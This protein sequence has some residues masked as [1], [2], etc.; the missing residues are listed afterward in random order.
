VPVARRGRQWR[1][2][3]MR[4][5]TG[6]DKWGVGGRSRSRKLAAF[7][8]RNGPPDHFVRKRTA[9]HSRPRRSRK[10]WLLPFRTVAFV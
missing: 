2:C 4:Y 8:A 9:P 5:S 7:V 10:L 6:D 3:A 1:G